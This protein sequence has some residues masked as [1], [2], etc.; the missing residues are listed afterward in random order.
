M[1]GVASL[2]LSKKETSILEAHYVDVLTKLMKLH[3]KTPHSIIYF[4][5]GSLPFLGILHLEQLTLFALICHLKDDPL[6]RHAFYILSNLNK[7]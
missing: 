4:L 6:N 3:N 7:F 1:S 5:E 2:I